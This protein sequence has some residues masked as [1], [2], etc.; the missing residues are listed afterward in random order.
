M[1]A[2]LYLRHFSMTSAPFPVTP[3]TDA[4]YTGGSRRAMVDAVVHVL[5]N[6]RGIVKVVGES[7]TGTTTL[8]RHIAR[9]MGKEFTVHC[10]AD[11]FII[12]VLAAAFATGLL[13]EDDCMPATCACS[14]H[15][16]ESCGCEQFRRC[17]ST[18]KMRGCGDVAA[19]ALARY[20]ERW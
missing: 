14:A 9:T 7:G 8:C 15:D 17:R 20:R 2:S 4:Y 19:D 13:N 18:F 12:H 10:C 11:R 5:R 3:D 1:A 6:E 16:D